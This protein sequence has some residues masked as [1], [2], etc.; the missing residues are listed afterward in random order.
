MLPTVQVP[1]D[2]ISVH[3]IPFADSRM[4]LDIV[5]SCVL[6]ANFKLRILARP[7]QRAAQHAAELLFV[8]TYLRRRIG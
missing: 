6:R 1:T 8:V 7:D 3:F 4:N 2:K 5:K